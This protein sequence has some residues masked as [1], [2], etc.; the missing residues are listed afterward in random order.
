MS[1]DRV[2]ASR[3]G[4]VMFILGTLMAAASAYVDNWFTWVILALS[5]LLIL[6]GLVA[7]N[8][9]R[10]GGV[11]ELARFTGRPRTKE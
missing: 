9:A 6:V 7:I 8:T 4:V 5:I 1:K 11:E 2:S 10:K 3:F